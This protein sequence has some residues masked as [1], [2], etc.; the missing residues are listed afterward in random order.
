MV[1]SPLSGPH[2]FKV[3]EGKAF[4]AA[5]FRTGTSQLMEHDFMRDIPGALTWGVTRH[6]VCDAATLGLRQP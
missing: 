1:R 6:L 5:T 3:R 2:T 4:T